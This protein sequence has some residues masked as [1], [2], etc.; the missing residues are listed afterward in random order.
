MAVT[1]I[2]KISNTLSKSISYIEDERKTRNSEKSDNYSLTN[3]VYYAMNP[4]KTEKQVYVS[5]V[6]CNPER[7]VSEMEDIKRI[8]GKTGGIKA[9]HAIQSFAEGE[10]TPQ[11]AHEIGVRLAEEMWGD[12]FQVV[13]STHL[14]TEN[15]HNH[16]VINSVSFKDGKKLYDSLGHLASLRDK[17]DEL[18]LEY[19]ISTIKERKLEKSGLN[20]ENFKKK[21][22]ANNPYYDEVK[23]DIDRAIRQARD[24]FDFLTI[25]KETDYEVIIRA[26]KLSVRRM[27]HKRNIRIER[28]FGNEYQIERIKQRIQ[29]EKEIRVPFQEVYSRVYK[30]KKKYR[31]AKKYG[32]LQKKY[33][34]YSIDYTMLKKR[35]R[36]EDKEELKKLRQFSENTKFLVSRNINTI[37]ELLLYQNQ[38]ISKIEEI[39]SKLRKDKYLL[40]NPKITKEQALLIKNDIEQ[41]NLQ[42]EFAIA[43]ENK[44]K[45]I[46]KN[47][48]ERKE[49]QRDEYGNRYRYERS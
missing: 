24:Y 7:A 48:K 17:S 20:F 27:D 6:N 33:I 16:F 5:G 4:K 14:N 43:E 13:V 8:F 29:E 35:Q 41:L 26:N 34:N 36:L 31:Y 19:E 1:K 3:L 39:E 47:E 2:W 18:C 22:R 12:R 9:F 45:E 40:K 38:Q 23:C 30:P 46:A 10:V 37:E 28:I 32:N 21:T 42:K 49:I 15:L 11:E 44:C 25:M